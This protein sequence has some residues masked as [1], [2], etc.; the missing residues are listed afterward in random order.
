MILDKFQRQRMTKSNTKQT[1][2]QM[3]ARTLF[4]NYLRF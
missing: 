2:S 3:K 1:N 4:I